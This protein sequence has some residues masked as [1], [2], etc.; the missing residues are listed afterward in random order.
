MHYLR[1]IFV[2]VQKCSTFAPEN[3]KKDLNEKEFID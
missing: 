3:L 2:V 1:K